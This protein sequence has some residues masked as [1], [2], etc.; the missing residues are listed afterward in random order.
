M[1]VR[2]AV[3]L[4]KRDSRPIHEVVPAF[5][6]KC[7]ATPA[8]AVDAEANISNDPVFSECTS[9]GLDEPV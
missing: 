5:V 3:T 4:N 7:A 9:I 8:V 1:I 2:D 6:I